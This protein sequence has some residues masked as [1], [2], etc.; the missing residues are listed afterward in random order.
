MVRRPEAAGTVVDV[1]VVLGIGMQA[2]DL[3]DL[4]RVLADVGLP[5]GAGRRGEGGRF[6]QHLGAARDGEARRDRVAEAAVVGTV[7][8]RDEVG[9]FAQRAVEDGRGL[10]V[11]S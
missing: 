1:D 2:R 5:P 10:D 4:E 6:A 3:G 7:P 8:A 9:G 11:G